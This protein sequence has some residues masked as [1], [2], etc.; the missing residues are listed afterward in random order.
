MKKKEYSG[1]YCGNFHSMNT[2]ICQQVSTKYGCVA[3]PAV[4]YEAQIDR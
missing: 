3:G 2:L 4:G 1:I